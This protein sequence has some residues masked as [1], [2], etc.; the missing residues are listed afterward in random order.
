MNY[1]LVD[2]GFS[3]EIDG[4]EMSMSCTSKRSGATYMAKV[5]LGALASFIALL[6]I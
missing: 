1:K 6:S 5:F 2:V 4:M 3:V